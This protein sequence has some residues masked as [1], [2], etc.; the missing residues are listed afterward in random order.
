MRKERMS[1]K[2]FISGL[3][4]LLVGWPILLMGFAVS[5]IVAIFRSG[6]DVAYDFATWIKEEE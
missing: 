6:C 4:L 5:M 2:R 3:L 1:E